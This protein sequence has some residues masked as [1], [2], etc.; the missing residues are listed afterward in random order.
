MG[1]FFEPV[2]ARGMTISTDSNQTL[3]DKTRQYWIENGKAL[4]RFNTFCKNDSRIDV[5]L[6]PVFDGLT[7]IKWR[8]PAVGEVMT[9]SVPGCSRLG[10]C[11]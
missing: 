2:F 6:L 8:S 1:M 11:P 10:K 3:C 7:L 5:L 9:G 4:R